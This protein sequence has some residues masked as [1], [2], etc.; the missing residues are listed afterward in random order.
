MVRTAFRGTEVLKMNRICS[1][2]LGEK[3]SRQKP[4]DESNLRSNKGIEVAK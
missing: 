3:H 2:E 1:G 4:E